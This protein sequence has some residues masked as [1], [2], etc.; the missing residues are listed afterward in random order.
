MRTLYATGLIA[1]ACCGYD[2]P[3]QV[4]SNLDR[5]AAPSTE[6]LP[7]LITGTTAFA[8]DLYRAAAATDG[9]VLV[10]PHS[11]TTALTM[12]YAGAGGNT[13]TQMATAVHITLPPAELHE[14]MNALDLAL[15]SRADDADD[16][17]I[18]FHLDTA[19][20]LFADE[21]VAIAPAYLDTLAVNYGAGVHLADFADDPEGARDTIN[22]WVEHH[23]SGKIE[24]LF[25][26]DTIDAYTTAVLVN[27]MYFAAAWD[28]R[29]DA[30]DD[31]AFAGAGSVATMHGHFPGGYGEGER[32]RA[33]D[34]N[35]DGDAVAMTVVLPELLPG[36]TGDPLALLEANLTGDKLAEIQ[37]AVATEADLQVALPRF[38]FTR[39]ISL[40]QTLESFGM[41]DAFE[42]EIADFSLLFEQGDFFIHHVLHK[43]Y[44]DV[45]E[46]G[47][48]AAAATGVSF[49]DDAAELPIEFTVDRPFLF[50]LRDKPTG[51][52]LFIGRVT[53]PTAS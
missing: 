35:Y 43:T 48:E 41:T 22:G 20:T 5:V 8:A 26:A 9:N 44:I 34:L 31:Q 10:S 21:D 32:F 46:N 14:A 15:A 2:E 50:I 29:F 49:G 38:K 3:P 23:T 40:N 47:T 1:I 28:V 24:E 18:P 37:S 53:D 45:N 19:N 4:K 52:I 13:A 7:E 51:E 39:Q 12:A 11:V 36:E 33:V 17:D 30:T 42:R 25:P 16:F 27:A 6:H